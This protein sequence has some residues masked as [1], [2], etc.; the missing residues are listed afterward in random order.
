L[1]DLKDKNKVKEMYDNPSFLN[2]TLSYWKDFVGGADV[3]IIELANTVFS[4]RILTYG[5][6]SGK[7]KVIS[8]T[9]FIDNGKLQYF[10]SNRDL[11][12][13]VKPIVVKAEYEFNK[14]NKSKCETE[15]GCT[16]F[17]TVQLSEPVFAFNEKAE[18][19]DD[20]KKNPFSYCLRSQGSVICE[21]S[22]ETEKRHSQ[23]WN[24]LGE[25]TYENGTPNPKW[26][27]ELPAVATDAGSI[28]TTYK[29]T[30]G[31]LNEMTA[32]FENQVG[33]K[34]DSVV[35]MIYLAKRDKATDQTNHTPKPGD[36]IK[37]RES[38]SVFVDAFG[39]GFNRREVG[40]LITGKN[41][42]SK[43]PVKTGVVDP[44][45]PKSP[46]REVFEGN[47]KEPPWMYDPNKWENPK[48]ADSLFNTKDYGRVT[49]F[50]PIPDYFGRP[51]SV[52]RAYYPGTIGTILKISDNVV[53][54]VC[55][56]IRECRGTCTTKYG[57]DIPDIPPDGDCSSISQSM[58]N[59]IARGINMHAKVYYHTNLGDYTAHRSPVVAQCA[60]DLFKDENGEGTCL[61]NKLNFY[62]AW[63]MKTNTDRYVGTGAYVSVSE[64]YWQ[65]EYKKKQGSGVA[66]TAKPK[67]FNKD[68][69]IDIFGVRRGVR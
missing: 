40:V 22:L 42:Y 14:S 26:E 66:S 53:A 18:N 3:N 1:S 61:T 34:G 9:P 25:G 59:E 47:G 27:W 52:A 45:N 28:S 51:D 16:E 5:Y 30:N 4:E 11:L 19:I 17:L 12:D 8:Y 6:N 15:S 39:N 7:G 64:F 49:E 44:N 65:I 48:L 20:E 33:A 43:T 60:S 57:I 41:R 10:P 32:Y 38:G 58:L 56:F 50:L 67:V 55:K 21:P 23:S 68:E 69:F 54:E 35:N 24:N 37:I 13:R 63:N 46:I 29:P 31:A 62:L 36:W 2:N